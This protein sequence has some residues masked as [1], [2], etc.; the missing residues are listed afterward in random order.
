[1]PN[2]RNESYNPI[3]GTSFGK[4]C[5][6]DRFKL[7]LIQSHANKLTQNSHLEVRWFNTLTHLRCRHKRYKRIHCLRKESYFLILGTS[8]GGKCLGEKLN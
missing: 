7:A 6:S 4:E 3:L 2:L 1:M 5:S 8:Y